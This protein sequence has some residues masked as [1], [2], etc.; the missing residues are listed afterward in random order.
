MIYSLNSSAGVG[1][2]QTRR[3]RCARS[4]AAYM[5]SQRPHHVLHS[6]L[7]CRYHIFCSSH[8]C[9][10]LLFARVVITFLRQR[11]QPF[12]TANVWETSLNAVRIH[13][14]VLCYGRCYVDVWTAEAKRQKQKNS[15]HA[16]AIHV[17]NGRPSLVSMGNYSTVLDQYC[18]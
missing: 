3:T 11:F 2:T 16:R 7:L 15:V 14:H 10:V 17:P 8:S 18:Q 6:S 1:M 9:P 13:L 4:R 12:Q 5:S